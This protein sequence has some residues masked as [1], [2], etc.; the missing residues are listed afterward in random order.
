MFLNSREETLKSN[1]PFQMSFWKKMFVCLSAWLFW[2]CRRT[3]LRSNDLVSE[4][5]DVGLMTMLFSVTVTRSFAPPPQSICLPVPQACCLVTDLRLCK[6]CP[7]VEPLVSLVNP[8]IMPESKSDN[9]HV[10]LQ[11]W[12]CVCLG[13]GCIELPSPLARD[14]IVLIVW[15]RL[16]W[17][18]L[19]LPC[20]LQMN[21]PL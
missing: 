6:L 10:F 9:S 21:F 4:G 8:S 3:R 19:S 11:L 16:P 17:L 12:L 14:V 20:S 7:S 2:K 18:I 5:V 1:K 15:K 13:G